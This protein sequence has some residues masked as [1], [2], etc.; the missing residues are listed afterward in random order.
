MPTSPGRIS[1][2]GQLQSVGW[3]AVAFDVSENADTGIPSSSS[4]MLAEAISKLQTLPRSRHHEQPFS[5]VKTEIGDWFNVPKDA[6][7]QFSL[8]LAEYFKRFRSRLGVVF[9]LEPKRPTRWLAA[10]IL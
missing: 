5:H 6:T 7:E 9:D 2:R 4:Q 1:R 10:R 8:S 3:P